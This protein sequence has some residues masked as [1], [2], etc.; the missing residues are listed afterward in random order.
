M[1]MAVYLSCSAWGRL[2]TVLGVKVRGQERPY[3]RSL[4]NLQGSE[5]SIK[6]G[7]I[8]QKLLRISRQ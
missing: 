7:S 4:S 1:Q 5:Q 8:V 3:K 2:A 6:A